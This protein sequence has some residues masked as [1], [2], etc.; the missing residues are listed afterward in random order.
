M[1]RI[2]IKRT[3]FP[4]VAFVFFIIAGLFI[5]SSVFS[6]GVLA[7]DESTKPVFKGKI[8]IGRAHV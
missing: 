2:F 7:G 4:L 1:K 5:A 8:E 3:V 6:S